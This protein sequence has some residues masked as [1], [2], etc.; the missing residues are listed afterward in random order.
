P[1]CR[2]ARGPLPSQ[3]VAGRASRAGRGTRHHAATRPRRPWRRR[4]S[5][6]RRSRWSFCGLAPRPPTDPEADLRPVGE[7]LPRDGPLSEDA[8][9]PQPG[10]Y[11]IAD[12]A[13]PAMLRLDLRPRRGEPLPHHLRDH[14]LRWDERRWRRR[15]AAGPGDLAPPRAPATGPIARTE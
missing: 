5:R 13:D 15:R 3:A 11:R 2:R 10:R 9:P 4:R 8:A 14:A 7:T 1:A 6:W 12:L